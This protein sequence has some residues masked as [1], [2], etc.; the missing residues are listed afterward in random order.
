MLWDYILEK[1]NIVYTVQSFVL[2]YCKT[3][4]LREKVNISIPE[5]ND[6]K[7]KNSISENWMKEKT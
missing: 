4:Y 2:G 7:Y 6:I 1:F 3:T 5:L